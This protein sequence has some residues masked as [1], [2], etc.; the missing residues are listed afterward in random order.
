MPSSTHAGTDLILD[1]KSSGPVAEISQMKGDNL[2]WKIII[3]PHK[4]KCLY[5]NL[6][7]F[8]ILFSF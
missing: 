6:L 8:Y 7:L 2:N 5:T 3:K 4:S 1:T